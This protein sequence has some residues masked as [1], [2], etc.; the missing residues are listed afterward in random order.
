MWGSFWHGTG[1]GQK[2]QIL[3]GIRVAYLHAS[4]PVLS[5]FYTQ[6]YQG[7]AGKTPNIK[8]KSAAALRAVFFLSI[9][10]KT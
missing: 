4:G 8:K 7:G 1:G 9:F 10:Y 3:A 5:N 2:V 6:A